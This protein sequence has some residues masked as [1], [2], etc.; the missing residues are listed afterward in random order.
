[1]MVLQKGWK[2]LEFFLAMISN[3]LIIREGRSKYKRGLFQSDPS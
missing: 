3:L 1:M 2:A